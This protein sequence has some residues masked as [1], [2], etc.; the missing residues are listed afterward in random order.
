MAKFEKVIDKINEKGI[1]TAKEIRALGVSK[2]SIKN[3]VDAGKLERVSRGV[4]ILP[5]ELVDMMY[6]MQLKCSKG[7]FSHE[8]ALL[9]HDLSDRTPSCNVMTLP[10]GYNNQSLKNYPIEL[11]WVKKNIHELGVIDMES[12]FGNPIRV[13]DMERT[14]CDIIK[15]RK[16]MDVSIVNQAVRDYMRR[17]DAKKFMLTIY[18]KK[19]GISDMINNYMEVLR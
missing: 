8:T 3:W 6:L 1:I 11:K 4:Y 19:M 10:K 18:A 5:N 7:I 9:L 12:M 16:H 2:T 14:I 17:K 13:Y 15:H